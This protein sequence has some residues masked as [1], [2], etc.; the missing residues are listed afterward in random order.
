[1]S[2]RRRKRASRFCLREIIIIII[3]IA[4]FWSRRPMR[5]LP[6]LL[7]P[8]G[9][10]EALSAAVRGGADAVYFG[11]RTANARNAA[12]N[13]SDGEI[14]QA[15][16]FLRDNGRY[17]YIALNILHTDRELPEV[18][19]F[20]ELCVKSGAHAFIIQDLGL[21]QIIR[22]YFSRSDI[23]LHAST[24]AAGHNSD[25]ARR[26]C[27]LGFSRMVAAR[28]LDCDNLKY[29]IDNSPIE[30]EIFAHGALCSS[31]SGRCFM[32]LALGGARSANRGMCAQ[33]CRLR[34]E[35]GYVLSLKDLC[36]A[37]RVKELI[38]L[39]PAGLKIEGRM[40]APEYVYNVCKVYRAC[41]DEGRNATG[42]EIDFL[43]GV[44][45]RSGFTD[46]YYARRLGR[47][48]YGIRTEENKAESKKHKNKS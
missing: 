31:H 3:I 13:F 26:L 30:T 6:E 35:S 17:A 18:L 16:K 38:E 36:L 33:P 40:K 46:G 12:K 7:A 23:K 15:V 14:A 2:G 25:A 29:L 27:E 44:F 11:G 39:S 41:L 20:A 47:D 42:A 34:Y 37:G 5:R 19:K 22:N 21:A 43:A 24:Q 9:S 8:A 1:M 32:S 48:M 45:S 28:E 10:P 4:I